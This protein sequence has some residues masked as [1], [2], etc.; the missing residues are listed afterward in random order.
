M[1]E[2]R[3]PS[4]RLGYIQL[5]DLRQRSKGNTMEQRQSPHQT[6]LEQQHTKKQKSTLYPSQTLT[7]NGSQT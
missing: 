4:N 3:E 5:N 2:N 1:E 6:V 7:H